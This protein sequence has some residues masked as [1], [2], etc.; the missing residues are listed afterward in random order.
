MA[1]F[2]MGN[3]TFK[4]YYR[5]IILETKEIPWKSEPWYSVS[6]PPISTVTRVGQLG[7]LIPEIRLD[8]YPHHHI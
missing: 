7:F 3:S 6:I 4:S 2:K 1:H 8:Y 5:N